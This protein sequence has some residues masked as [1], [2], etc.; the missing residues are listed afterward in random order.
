MEV[1][2]TGAD[3]AAA[4]QGNLGLPAAGQERPHDEE[5]GT[6]LPHQ[7]I[8]RFAAADD[9][10][11]HRQ[12]MLGF[13]KGRLDPQLPQHLGDG[14]DVFQCR[15]LVQHALRLLA[16]QGGGDDGQHRILRPADLHPPTHG[17]ASMYDKF[18]HSSLQ[19]P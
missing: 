4:G 18:F 17:T 3:G 8:G 12:L 11:V 9:P 6:H 7:L 2:G 10:A 5:G 15:H 19:S 13:I 14:I 1:D 16:Q